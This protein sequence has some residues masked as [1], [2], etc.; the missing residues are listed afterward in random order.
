MAKFSAAWTV[1]SHGPIETLSDNLW[2]VQ[3]ALPKMSLER[4]MTVARRSD[5]RLVL[6]NAIALNESAQRELETLGDFGY[7]LVPNGYHR[8]DAP[9]YK[10]RYPTLTVLAPR[11]SRSKVEQAVRVD[12]TYEDFPEDPAVSLYTLPGVGEQEGAMLVRSKDG[13][14]VVVNDIVFNMDRKRDVLGW[15][16]TTLLGSAPGPRVSRLAKL[17]LVKDRKVVRAELER[18]SA[19]PDL[20]RLI[21]AHEKVAHGPDAA[22]A[23]LQAATYL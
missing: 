15:L 1:L 18:L 3:G 16:F 19:S 21:V 9:A 10:E 13:L 7:M 5:G 17:A 14:T 23:L 12:G 22:R 11:G 8:L 20:V 4:V 2:R 6:H